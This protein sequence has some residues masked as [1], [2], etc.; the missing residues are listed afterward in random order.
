MEYHKAGTK[1]LNFTAKDQ[2][3]TVTIKG[4]RV[5]GVEGMV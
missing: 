3:N 1:W 2:E 5:K 4:I